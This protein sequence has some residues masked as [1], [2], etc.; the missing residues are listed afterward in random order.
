[1]SLNSARAVQS[2]SGSIYTLQFYGYIGAG[3]A[4]NELIGQ[5]QAQSP[6]TAMTYTEEGTTEMAGLGYFIFPSGTAYSNN[7]SATNPVTI[8]I[9]SITSTNVQGT[10]KGD[11]FN[12]AD[13][14]VL[15]S[16]TFN[17]NF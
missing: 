1:M 16:G 17:L 3:G 7:H 6:I 2:S 5:I 13:K 12:G 8:T 11:I 10:F 15:A 14:K 9:T 4:S